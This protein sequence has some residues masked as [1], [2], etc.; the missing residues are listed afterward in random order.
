MFMDQKGK[1][2]GKI[3]VIDLLVIVV[4]LVGIFGSC[5]AY[6]KVKSGKVL[7]ENKALLKQDNTLDELE[8]TMRLKEVRS[9][10][11]DSVHVGDD[12]YA[13]DTNKFLG[14]I[15]EVKTEPAKRV[16]TGFDGTAK[17]AEVPERMDVILTVRV[18]GKRT[19]GGYFTGNN[20]HLVYD[21]A[22]EIKTPTIQTTPVIE[23]IRTVEKEAE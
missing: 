5:A 3:S 16:V 1:L 14:E 4:V 22:F 8:V 21:S 9:M 10:T 23:G 13:K 19:D 12:V 11:R 20:I 17:E 15:I 18:P 6:Q 7:T 2:F